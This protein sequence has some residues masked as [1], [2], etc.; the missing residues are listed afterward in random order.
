MQCNS[1]CASIDAHN[2]A[3]EPERYDALCKVL[4]LPS[5]VSVCEQI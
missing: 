1:V 2:D 4:D 3:L 5:F